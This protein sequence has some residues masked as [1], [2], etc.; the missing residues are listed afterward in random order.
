MLTVYMLDEELCEVVELHV[1][2][3]GTP[4]FL[5]PAAPTEERNYNHN[6][7]ERVIGRSLPFPAGQPP[8]VNAQP[9]IGRFL[10]F[11]AG[12]PL[13]VNA[14]LVIGRSLPFPT[15]QPP[16]VNAQGIGPSGVR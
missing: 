1:L 14:Q 15:G 2:F 7:S 4:S 8:P 6:A 13:P 3:C 12:Q 10:P 9:V 5:T 11:P 16:P